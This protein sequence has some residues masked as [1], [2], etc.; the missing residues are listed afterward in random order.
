MKLPHD[1]NDEYIRRFG[2]IRNHKNQPTPEA[3]QHI[4]SR[5]VQ[6]TFRLWQFLVDDLGCTVV[7]LKPGSK[8]PAERWRH[9]PYR[10][11]AELMLRPEDN[12][13]IRTGHLSGLLVLD[14]DSQEQFSQWLTKH[15]RD[16][17]KTIRVSTGKGY[18]YYYSFPKEFTNGYSKGMGAATTGADILANERYIVAPLSVHPSGRLY[19]PEFTEFKPTAPEPWMLLASEHGWQPGNE[20]HDVSIG[21]LPEVDI[22]TLPREVKDLISTEAPFDRSGHEFR[23]VA[24]MNQLGYTV[25]EAAAVLQVHGPKARQ[26]GLEYIRGLLS[27]FDW[28]SHHIAARKPIP[29]TKECW[30]LLAKTA[31][32]HTMQ[33]LRH[34]GNE[35]SKA[36]E[37]ALRVVHNTFTGLISG[38]LKGRIALPLPPGYGKTTSIIAYLSMAYRLGAFPRKRVAI[39]STRVEQV[40]DGY[41]QAMKAG[42]PENLLA[43]VHSYDDASEKAILDPDRPIVF[44]THSKVKHDGA[45]VKEDQIFAFDHTTYLQNR[46]LVIWDESFIASEMELVKQTDLIMEFGALEAMYERRRLSESKVYSLGHEVTPEH[47][48]EAMSFLRDCIAVIDKAIEEEDTG[49]LSFPESTPSDRRGY[50]DILITIAEETQRQKASKI[51]G[52]KRFLRML[53]NAMVLMLVNQGS[54]VLRTMLSVPEDVCADMAILDASAEIKYLMTLDESVHLP[55]FESMPE[56]THSYENVTFHRLNF[57]AG[58]GS[59]ERELATGKGGLIEAIVEIVTQMPDDPFLFFTF[60]HRQPQDFDCTKALKDALTAAGVDLE[61]LSDGKPQ[62]NWLTLGNETASNDYAHCKH[63]VFV[64]LLHYSEEVI[65]GRILAQ[66]QDLTANLSKRFVD[67]IHRSE[68]CYAIHQGACRTAMRVIKNDIADKVDVWYTY[69]NDLLQPELTKVFPKA[70]WVVHASDAIKPT[71]KVERVKA[72]II[73]YLSSTQRPKVSNREIKAHVQQAFD[74]TFSARLFTESIKSVHD[75]DDIPWARDRQSMKRAE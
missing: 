40:C 67:Q 49:I 70:T 39:L 33:T 12:L 25:E 57:Y 61:A 5:D 43:L 63:A 37:E 36:H 56:L 38:N 32:R 14:I 50:R 45:Q 35:P 15:S 23:I 18:H 28:V 72:L 29:P 31:H 7:K 60:K 54:M 11:W 68:H 52:I 2:E 27:K 19:Q 59:T 62:Y 10:S 26:R 20:T 16:I 1:Y 55:A 8:E 21:D 13:A 69:P 65:R 46:D 44:L 64:G 71:T 4:Q 74:E 42:I 22:N 75:D 47:E 53:D 51:A 41:R 9:T 34:F 6:A 30:D 24:L 58:R 3:L 66:K 73:D 48:R 17:K